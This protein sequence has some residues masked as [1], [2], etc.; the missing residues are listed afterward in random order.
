VE[1]GRHRSAEGKQASHMLI[2]VRTKDGTERLQVENGATLGTLRATIA[3]QLAV[4]L[5]QQV[6]AAHVLVCAGCSLS[7]VQACC[8]T[9]SSQNSARAFVLGTLKL[10]SGIS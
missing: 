5:E 10:L 9:A 6:Q 1:K 3:T 7:C 4:P 2:R 8:V